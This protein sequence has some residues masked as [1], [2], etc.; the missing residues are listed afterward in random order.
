MTNELLT[1]PQKVSREPYPGHLDYNNVRQR[2]QDENPTKTKTAPQGK[3]FRMECE[4]AGREMGC[5]NCLQI[6]GSWGK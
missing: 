5:S 4:P 1:T 2:N 3:Q 6:V